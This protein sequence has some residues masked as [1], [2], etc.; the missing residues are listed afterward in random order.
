MSQPSDDV[1]Q[2]PRLLVRGRL[3]I[4]VTTSLTLG[5]GALAYWLQIG[6][7]DAT[8]TQKQIE[9][10]SGVVCAV[11]AVGVPLRE[12]WL[13]ARSRRAA[14]GLASDAKRELRVAISDVLEPLTGLV[15]HINKQS[16]PVKQRNVGTGVQA[17]VAA[18][19]NIAGAGRARA[20]FFRMEAGSGQRPRQL[21]PANFSG[22]SGKPKSD[23]VKG[24]AE[25]DAA[26][27]MCDRQERRYC[28]DVQTDPPPGWGGTTSG[29]R[30]FV[31]VPVVAGTQCFGMLTV[32]AMVPGDL[33]HEEERGLVDVLAHLLGAILSA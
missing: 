13:E 15:A 6:V 1:L 10:W 33:A 16:G 3:R 27:G 8:G 30:T 21:I 28:Y 20:C 25:G 17:V 29:Y 5:S 11:L 18:A 4:V 12:Q 7:A 32:D 22:R 14:E 24:T 9:T 23:F 26:I 31:A 2:A 19:A